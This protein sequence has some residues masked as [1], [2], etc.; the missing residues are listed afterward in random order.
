MERVKNEMVVRNFVGGYEAV[1]SHTQNLYM[2]GNK[3]INY[4]T[5]IAIN[6]GNKIYL[7]KNKY[8]VTTSKIQ[9]MIRRET[10]TNM[11]VELTEKELKELS[12]V[13]N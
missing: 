9:N 11:L 10:P 1:Q 6:A 12:L 2:E 13:N 3:L 8:S 7:N 5:V 4:Y